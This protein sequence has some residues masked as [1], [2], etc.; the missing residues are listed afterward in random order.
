MQRRGDRRPTRH[1]ST[2]AATTAGQRRRA[3][4]GPHRTG[5]PRPSGDVPCRAEAA[6]EPDRGPARLC[7]TERPQ[8]LVSTMVRKDAPA[9]PGGADGDR[10]DMTLERRA[11]RPGAYVEGQAHRV[12]LHPAEELRLGARTCGVMVDLSTPCHAARSDIRTGPLAMMVR[13]RFSSVGERSLPVAKHR[14]GNQPG[15]GWASAAE[16]PPCRFVAPARPFGVRFHGR[17]GRY[18]ASI[19]SSGDVGVGHT[20]LAAPSCDR[21]SVWREAGWPSSVGS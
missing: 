14:G 8:P 20:R 19:D 10:A 18:G 17:P 11:R 15:G 6:S 1:A 2:D 9:V 5:T 16:P 4:P 13:N 3:M 7:R 12:W 21:R